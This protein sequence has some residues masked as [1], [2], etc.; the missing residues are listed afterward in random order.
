M[1]LKEPR[2]KAGDALPDAADVVIVGA[3][4]IGLG[5]A[6]ELSR[7]GVLAVVVER[8]QAGGGASGGNAG[9]VVPSHVLPVTEPSMLRTAVR[10]MLR[11]TGPV[12][13]RASLRLAYLGWLARFLGNCR[14]ARVEAAAPVLAEL[15]ALSAG[16]FKEWLAAAPIDCGYVPN[17]LL[18]V[19]GTRAA[20]AAGRERAEWEARFG[21]RVEVLTPKQARAREPLLNASVAGAI[22]YPDDAGLEPGRFVAGLA[23]VLRQR[24][25]RL[26][27]QAEV[28]ALAATGRGRVVSTSRGDIRADEVVLAAGA[29]T[30]AVAAK[31]GARVP[32]VPAKGYSLTSAMP[33]PAVRQRMLLGEKHVAVAPMGDQLRLS[34]WFELGRWDRT[35]PA[36]RLARVEANAR[37]RLALDAPLR[38]T[39]RWA[40]L[41]PVTPDGL[42]IIGR[43]AAPG[44]CL[45]SGHAMLGMTLTPATARLV[46]QTLCGEPPEVDLRPLSPRRFG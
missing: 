27:E 40:G 23:A 31:A 25:V 46:A 18:H 4:A 10:G 26:V 13:V 28:R 7:R 34:G 45:A 12:T 9:F 17:G 39:R 42:P 41:R 24:G 1:P 30:P 14:A 32:I 36:A 15:A 11:R 22:F 3:G 29:W 44:L 8:G 2:P 33:A 16:L 19:F 21:V 37:A 35:L 38:V 5:I 20:L 6:W 43:G